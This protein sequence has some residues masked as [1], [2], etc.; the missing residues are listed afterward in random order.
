MTGLKRCM[1]IWAANNNATDEQWRTDRTLAVLQ[2]IMMK[3][4]HKDYWP[5]ES[6]D[7]SVAAAIVEMTCDGNRVYSRSS[8]SPIANVKSSAAAKKLI[9]DN[10][11]SPA[12]LLVKQKAKV[13]MSINNLSC[14]VMLRTSTRK[15]RN[16]QK[17]FKTSF[18]SGV[19]VQQIGRLMRLLLNGDVLEFNKDNEVFGYLNY[20]MQPN[21]SYKD[22]ADL[23]DDLSFKFFAPDN[24]MWDKAFNEI[25]EQYNSLE[26]DE[27][28]LRM[29][30]NASAVCT[31]CGAPCTVCNSEEES[32]QPALRVV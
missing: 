18:V 10:E 1:I 22:R 7:V 16:P 14:G 12:V 27:Q 9:S 5:Q 23:L 20:F 21:L 31:S 8:A 17:G 3:N 30:E 24:G 28:N 29:L 13:G 19:S 4:A 15:F 11:A 26:E 32:V 2:D 25:R 6:R